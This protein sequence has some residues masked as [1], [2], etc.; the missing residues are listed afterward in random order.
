MGLALLTIGLGMASVVVF[1][2]PSEASDWD[3]AGKAFAVLEGMRVI[4]G[5]NVDIIGHITG[6]NK[7]GSLWNSSGYHVSPQQGV[8]PRKRH[9]QSVWVPKYVWKREYIPEHEEYS[10]TYGTV[11]VEGHYIKYPV[12]EGGYWTS[13]VPRANHTSYARYPFR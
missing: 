8:G 13:Q 10:E 3:K 6:I 11:I 2:T 1:A 5:G 12:E 7:G 9:S 4:T